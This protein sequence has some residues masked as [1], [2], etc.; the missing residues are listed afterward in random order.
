MYMPKGTDITKLYIVGVWK[1]VDF[2]RAKTVV[3]VFQ[4]KKPN[5]KAE[6]KQLLQ[7]DY[8][9]GIMELK[10]NPKFENSLLRYMKISTSPLIIAN[11]IYIIK[12][13]DIYD[14]L[15]ENYEWRDSTHISI[16][17]RKACTNYH[18]FFQ[19]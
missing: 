1:D 8:E 16:Y 5:L 15:Y 17:N 3:S 12:L 18:K 13:K 19:S 6:F 2:E 7:T 11:D 10:K 4:S 9:F 14:I